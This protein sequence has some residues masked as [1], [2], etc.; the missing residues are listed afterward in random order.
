MVGFVRKMVSLATV[1]GVEVA[2]VRGIV[3]MPH[4]QIR[5]PLFLNPAKRAVLPVEVAGVAAG[6]KTF[7]ALLSVPIP[8]P[9]LEMRGFRLM[10]AV[11]SVAAE[12]E[13]RPTPHSLPYI[14]QEVVAEVVALAVSE[15][16]ELP[17][18]P[19][20]LLIPRLKIVLL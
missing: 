9:S 10:V 4:L 13:V 18:T 14:T 7:A 11:V 15:T 6:H 16:P 8:L 19:V 3:T 1:L 12:V 5:T 20:A 2:G 17:E